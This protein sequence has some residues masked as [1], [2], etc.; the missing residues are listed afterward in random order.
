MF[1]V[2]AKCCSLTSWCCMVS[3]AKLKTSDDGVTF[4]SCVREGQ[5]PGSGR[6]EPALSRTACSRYFIGRHF[7][8]RVLLHQ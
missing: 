6:S 2:L 7:T 3:D 1:W 5:I 4:D 8:C